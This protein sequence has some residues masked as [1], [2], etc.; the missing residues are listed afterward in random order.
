M[1]FSKRF[2]LAL[3]EY[4]RALTL[5]LEKQPR[6]Q[7]G[8]IGRART[9][10]EESL[11]TSPQLRDAPFANKAV[12]SLESGYANAQPDRSE[13]DDRG[14]KSVKSDEMAILMR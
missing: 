9:L 8:L 10:L 14:V 6:V 5:T 2:G 1:L 12:I 4:D 11:D 13:T 7:R 3:T